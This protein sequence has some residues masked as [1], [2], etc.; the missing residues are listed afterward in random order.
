M[1]YRQCTCR[2]HCVRSSNYYGECSCGERQA[3]RQRN[4]MLHSEPYKF[5]GI[6]NSFPLL[7]LGDREN[8]HEQTVNFSENHAQKSKNSGCIVEGVFAVEVTAFY[9]SLPIKNGIR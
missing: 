9:I 7:N 8:R 3:D 5:I 1:I 6:I 4:G 2:Q